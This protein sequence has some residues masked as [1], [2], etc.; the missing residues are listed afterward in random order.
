MEEFNALVDEANKIFL[1]NF[2][3]STWFGRCIF[4]SWY[5]D[6]GTCDFCFRSTVK[7]KIKH[8]QSAR[9]SVASILTDAIIG[10][11]LGWRIEF[12]TGGYRIFSFPEIVDIARKVSEVYGEKIWVNLGA[13]SRDELETLHPYVEGVCASIETINPQLHKKICPDKPIEPYSDMLKTAG[14]MGFAKSMTIVVGLGESQDDFGMLAEFIETHNLDRITFYALKPVQGTPYTKSPEPEEY[15]WWIAK[16]RVRFPKIEIMAGLTP[17]RSADYAELLLRAGANAITK[18]PA[19][20]RFGSA[21]AKEIERQAAAA[22]RKFHG[23][24]TELP[25]VDWDSEVDALPF[26]DELKGQIKKKIMEY[27]DGISGK[28]Q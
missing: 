18:F 1:E 7:H 2:D 13:L 10:K 12:L 20:K 19:L 21:D 9:R 15:V 24:L 6:V 3:D 11:K 17:R 22:G 16:T 5:C 28:E 4:L 14:E 23:S 27:V 25:A 8:S 26:D